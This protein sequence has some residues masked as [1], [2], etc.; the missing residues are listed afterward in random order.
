MVTHQMTE[1]GEVNGV[2]FLPGTIIDVQTHD[3]EKLFRSGK[4]IRVDEEGVIDQNNVDIN[5]IDANANDKAAGILDD[6]TP[7]PS[8]PENEADGE[9]LQ[10]VVEEDADTKA[11]QPQEVSEVD[12]EIEAN[13][14]Q[15]TE[16]GEEPKAT[17][18]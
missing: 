9:A 16:A 4:A 15:E 10:G 1:P 18:S 3:A 12:I 13:Q 6:D 7:A 11:D 14:P 5:D 2:R 17:T 8:E